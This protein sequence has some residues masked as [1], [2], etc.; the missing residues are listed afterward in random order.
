VRRRLRK[1][2]H[3]RHLTNVC[4]DAVA[5]DRDL[6]QRLLESEP[7]VPVR[8]EGLPGEFSRRLVVGLGLRYSVALLRKVAP[9]T[10]VVIYWADEFPTVHERAVIFS[11]S[12][13]GLGKPPA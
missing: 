13:L 5:F 2:V 11:A 8:I 6:R 12:D 7:G 10:A 3:R 4:A 9:A 1:K